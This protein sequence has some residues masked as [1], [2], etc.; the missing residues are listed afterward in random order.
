MNIDKVWDQG[1]TGRNMT[2]AVIDDGVN[3]KHIDL[4]S[5]YVSA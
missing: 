3:Y 2:V 5:N 1:I 4:E